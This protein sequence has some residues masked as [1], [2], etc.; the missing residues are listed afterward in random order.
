MLL[1]NILV[2]LACAAIVVKIFLSG[3]DAPRSAAALLATALVLTVLITCNAM[4]ALRVFALASDALIIAFIALM[5][6]ISV[7]DSNARETD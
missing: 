2:G 3:E 1:L 7:R 5:W 4:I 6:A